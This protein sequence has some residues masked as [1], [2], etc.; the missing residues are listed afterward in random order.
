M[1]TSPDTIV[2]ASA[3]PRRRELLTQIGVPHVV[4]AVDIDES[5]QPGEAPA[6]LARRLARG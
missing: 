6:A 1:N 5:A 4:L 3:S 2:L